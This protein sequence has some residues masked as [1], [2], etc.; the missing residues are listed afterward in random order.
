MPFAA[1]T[2]GA[3]ASSAPKGDI[4]AR[5][6]RDASPRSFGACRASCTTRR[7][8]SASC[9]AHWR[10][11]LARH[12]ERTVQRGV[13]GRASPSASLSWTQTASTHL[14]ATLSA[15]T[16]SRAD[17]ICV[18]GRAVYNMLRSL[19]GFGDQVGH[20]AQPP[21]AWSPNPAR[22]WLCVLERKAK[23]Q[24]APITCFMHP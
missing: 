10:H 7:T 15:F 24:V 22:G 9:P 4:L 3:T 19:R 17:F 20:N 12:A 13:L 14:P 5:V 8:T 23:T 16:L 6:S 1:M 11:A 21:P 18:Y 2:A